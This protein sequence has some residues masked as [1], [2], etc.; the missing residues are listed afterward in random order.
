MVAP[1]RLALLA[2]VLLTAAACTGAPDPASTSVAPTTSLTASTSSTS[3]TTLPP[4]T[5][6]TALYVPTYTIDLVEE[7]A[8]SEFRE[9]DEVIELPWGDGA[10][11]AGHNEIIGPF[12]I[13]VASDGA[14]VLSDIVNLRV[15]I[16]RDGD[17]SVLMQSTE[18]SLLLPYGVAA[19]DNGLVAV[20]GFLR[21]GRGIKAHTL[22]LF[23]R[24]GTLIDQ[25]RVPSIMNDQWG[26]GE[27]V[28]AAFGPG[29]IPQ[30]WIRLTEGDQILDFHDAEL[31][32]FNEEV[33]E[34]GRRGQVSHPVETMLAFGY[35]ETRDDSGVVLGVS[36]G[37]GWVNTNPLDPFEATITR[38]DQTEQW[39][40]ENWGLDGG[41]WAP[42]VWEV[43][44]E[45]LVTVA[46]LHMDGPFQWF[47]VDARRGGHYSVFRIVGDQTY[48]TDIWDY[49]RIEDG[50]LYVLQA[51]SDGARIEIYNLEPAQ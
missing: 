32:A 29:A 38:G 31:D 45:R 5:T 41:P 27:H 15:Q 2:A 14:I 19:L 46:G 10:G 28:W 24:D 1:R 21:G 34:R 51:A 44:D 25:G 37:Q 18:R 4:A 7:A 39:M 49:A 47:V 22:L 11:D 43:D 36:G 30:Y 26:G 50:R 6:T 48:E 42:H 23:D 12:A 3:T 13:D 20:Q 8:T 35:Q 9:P 33:E 17:W 16:Y 40:L